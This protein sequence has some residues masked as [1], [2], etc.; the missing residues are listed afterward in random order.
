[1]ETKTKTAASYK[2]S[3]KNV[4]L[5]KYLSS[6]FWYGFIVKIAFYILL[7]DLAFVF[8]Y[9]FIDMIVNSLKSESDIFNITVKWIPSKLFFQNYK[10]AW[11]QLQYMTYFKNSFIVAAVAITGHVISC[12][13]I[14]YGFSRY[15]FPCKNIM[16]GIVILSMIVPIQV[17]IFPQYM[18]FSKLGWLNTYL[19]LTVPAFFG[20]GLKGG[21]YIF[22]FRQFFMGLPYEMEEAARIDGCSS[23]KI[24]WKIILPMAKSSILVSIVL[25]MV[26]QWN[27]YFEPNMYLT[28]TKLYLL[29]AKLPDLYANLTNETMIESGTVVN[30]AVVLAA[31]FLVILPVLIVYTFLQK[32]F[33]EGIERSGLT[34]Q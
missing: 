13:F 2:V 15:K 28:N 20:F 30:I 11:E 6:H 14:A 31:T 22:L 23:F 32:K 24:F 4:W 33:V 34:G 18:L 5:H 16:F 8:L 7:L 29:P 26:W 17:L 1:M 10:I 21:L 27:D 25:S 19:P 9:P 3:K 12:S